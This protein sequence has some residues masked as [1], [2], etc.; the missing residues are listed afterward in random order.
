MINTYTLPC[1]IKLI[2]EKIDY[3]KSVSVGVWVKSGSAYEELKYHGMSHFIEHMLFKGT[4]TKTAE[5]I[6][7]AMDAVG[8]QMNAFTSRDC[9]CFYTKTLASDLDTSLELLSDIIINPL[10]DEKDIE[11]EKNVVKEEISMY[12]DTP[13]ELVMDLL[14]S[15]CYKGSS[16]GRT[17]LG[18]SESVSSFSKEDILEYMNKMYCSDNTVISVV[19]SFD[20]EKLIDKVWKYFE[21]M[22][23]GEKTSDIEK[24]IFHSGAVS[25]KK[26]IEQAHTA[27]CYPSYDAEDENMYAMTLVSNILG[28]GMSSR[29]FQNVREKY[30][31]CYSVY[32]YQTCGKNIGNVTLYSG[33]AKENADKVLCMMKEETQKLNNFT[34]DEL[35]RAKNQFKGSF[36]LGNEGI[37]GR[38]SSYGKQMLLYGKIKEESEI[39]EKI[40]RISMENAHDAL[41][42]FDN[43]FCTVSTVIPE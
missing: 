11:T 4:Q 12:E 22:H 23:R 33:C 39:L 5:D 15:E 10:L 9:T 30:G 18:T 14:Y 21:K 7:V 26:P 42:F 28:G 37:S 34:Y 27:I 19:G 20:E 17:I 25:V 16:T 6:A 2:C 8:G 40:N 31:L 36:V 1:G 38:M 35:T 32:A 24:P 43:D 3:V 41:K 29:L 13:D